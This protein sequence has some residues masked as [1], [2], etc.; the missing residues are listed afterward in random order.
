MVLQKLVLNELTHG[1]KTL[2]YLKRLKKHK[3]GLRGR[4]IN[5]I[6]VSMQIIAGILA[7]ITNMVTLSQTSTFFGMIKLFVAIGFF[8]NI[9]DLFSTAFPKAV[10]M[11][12][13]NLN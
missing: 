10:F 12:L 1:T 6:I 9:D 5:I 3:K 13:D 7:N 2:T 8:L 4:T 11:N